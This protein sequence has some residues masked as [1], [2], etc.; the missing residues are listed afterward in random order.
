MQIKICDF[1]GCLSTTLILILIEYASSKK[2][3]CENGSGNI[4][5]EVRFYK[6]PKGIDFR[7][8]KLQKYRSMHKI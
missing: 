2:I 8:K 7:L 3:H 6:L 1:S 5:S 4:K